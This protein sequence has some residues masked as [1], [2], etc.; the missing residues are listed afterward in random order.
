MDD[1][2]GKV[3]GNRRQAKLVK[4]SY[5]EEYE[6]DELPEK[7][8]KLEHLVQRLEAQ[9]LEPDFYNQP[10]ESIGPVVEDLEQKQSSLEELT[11]RWEELEKK[12]RQL[13]HR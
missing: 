5:K 9:I 1:K 8:E 4:L 13:E 3:K 11:T 2:N 6:L 7:I 10:W 12:K